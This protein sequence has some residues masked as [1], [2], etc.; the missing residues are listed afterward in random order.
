MIETIFPTKESGPYS[1]K[2]SRIRPTAAELDM[3]LTRMI[4]ITGTGIWQSAAGNFRSSDNTSR[5]PEALN[6][7]TAVISPIK[8]VHPHSFFCTIQEIVEYRPFCEDSGTNDIKYRERNH[9]F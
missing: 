3:I 6:T 2:I 7:P 9:E 5:I 4:G 8:V 1:L